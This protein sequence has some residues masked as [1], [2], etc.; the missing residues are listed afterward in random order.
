[1][2]IS[3]V[4]LTLNEIVGLKEIFH[5]VPLNSVDEV[6][7]IDGGSTDGTLEFFKEHNITVYPQKVKGRGEAFR[8]A[9]RKA[10]GDALILFSPDGNED[11]ND[12]PKFKPLLE[13]GNDIVIATRMIK[14]AHNEEDDQIIKLRKWVN[15][16]FT[17]LANLIWNKGKWVSDTINGYRAITKKAWSILALDGPGYT[18]EYQGSIRAFKKELKIAEFTTYEAKRI[19]SGE[20]SPSLPTGIAFIK[21]FFYEI[22]IG[23]N[24]KSFDIK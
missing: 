12:I 2:K 10:K 4:F 3:L 8:E 15:N 11:P 16:A 22:K 19:D 5:K 21:I 1:M 13:E 18:I 6:F 7:A 24:W 20:G 17:I 23:K 9:F 14:G